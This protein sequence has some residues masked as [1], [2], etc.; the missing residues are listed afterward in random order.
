MTL[1]AGLSMVTNAPFYSFKIVGGRSTVPFIVIV[2]IALGIALIA[3]DPPRVLFG[4][5]C[6]Y[7]LSGYLVYALAQVQGPADER[8]RHLD[9]RARRKGTASVTGA[10]ANMAAMSSIRSSLALELAPPP[11]VR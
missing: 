2:A 3:L 9:R 11:R 10:R 5:F 8:D 7:G 4:I 6:L 1:F